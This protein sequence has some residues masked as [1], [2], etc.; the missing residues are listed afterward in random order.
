MR[1]RGETR[2]TLN[3]DLGLQDDKHSKGGAV[4][5]HLQ[6]TIKTLTKAKHSDVRITMV[7]KKELNW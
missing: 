7:V 1:V 6:Q 5:Q 3:S 4:S 2:E